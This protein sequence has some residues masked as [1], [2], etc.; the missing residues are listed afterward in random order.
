MRGVYG[1]LFSLFFLFLLFYT[2]QGT[3]KVVYAQTST[4][5]EEARA[6]FQEGLD[7]ALREDLE[8]AV[9]K[10]QRA[11]VLDPTNPFFHYNL[12]LALG[13]KKDYMQAIQAFRQALRLKPDHLPSRFRLGLLYEVVGLNEKALEEY[14]Q[15]LGL[16]DRA[17]EVSVAQ[18][19][20]LLLQ[21]ALDD[22]QVRK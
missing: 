10:F 7:H 13:M 19:R 6:L 1:H 20:I 3:A 16:K 21:K 11:I 9:P 12:G 2:A 14:Q 15:V 17:W 18:Q 8:Q 22:H 4:A 5:P